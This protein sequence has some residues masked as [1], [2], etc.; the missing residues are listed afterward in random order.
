MEYYWELMTIYLT[1]NSNLNHGDY[2]DKKI[3]FL[4]YLYLPYIE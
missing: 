3:A 2:F 1:A 4:V